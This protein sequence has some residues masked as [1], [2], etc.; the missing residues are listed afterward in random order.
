MPPRGTTLVLSCPAVQ[1]AK[2]NWNEQ[3]GRR[4]VK[5]NVTFD[6]LFNLF[7]SDMRQIRIAE[8]VGLSRER[9]RQIY[10]SYFRDLYDARSGRQRYHA[11]TREKRLHEAEQR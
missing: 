10:D 3:L 11:Y 2:D 7:N 8:I 1:A 5:R 9:V 4:R 6:Q